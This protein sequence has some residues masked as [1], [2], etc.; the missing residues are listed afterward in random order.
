MKGLLELRENLLG[1]SGNLRRFNLAELRQ[2]VFKVKGRVLAADALITFA[3]GFS[4]T[5]RQRGT[6]DPER[7]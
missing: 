4:F 1:V 5:A 3:T 6:L 7:Q 2:L